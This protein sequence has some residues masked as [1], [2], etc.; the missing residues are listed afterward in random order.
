[1][2]PIFIK[3]TNFSM[4]TR[5]PAGPIYVNA[6]LIA[7]I[8]RKQSS[9][10]NAEWTW[11]SFPAMSSDDVHGEVVVETAEEIVARIREATR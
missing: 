2:K 3:L 4:S 8:E 9:S 11:I 6:S 10:S 7:T 5:Q 1:M